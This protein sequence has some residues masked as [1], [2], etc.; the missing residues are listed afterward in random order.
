MANATLFTGLSFHFDP[1]ICRIQDTSSPWFL[2]LIIHTVYINILEMLYINR[3]LYNI[4]NSSGRS[5]IVVRRTFQKC[6]RAVRGTVL[7]LKPDVKN[8]ISRHAYRPSC[9]EEAVN[10]HSFLFFVSVF[11]ASCKT[12]KEAAGISLHHPRASLS[13]QSH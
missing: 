1:K 13:V 4:G 10:V 3:F 12:H 6:P 2:E 8:G 9:H 11:T 7:F 5:N